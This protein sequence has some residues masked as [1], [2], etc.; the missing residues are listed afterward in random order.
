MK[1]AIIDEVHAHREKS[2]IGKYTFE[3]YKHIRKN[4]DADLLALT[5]DKKENIYEQDIEVIPPGIRLP[6]FQRTVNWQWYYP[7][8]MPEGY[9]IYHATNPFLIRTVALKPNSI[10]TIH[11]MGL[12]ELPGSSL[13]DSLSLLFG[14]SCVH[15]KV[16]KDNIR[17]IKKIIAVSNYTKDKIKDILGV[18]E[19]KIA[20]I[21]HGVNPV[22]KPM[23]GSDCRKELG[24]SPDKKIILY[25][26]TELPKKNVEILIK[27]LIEVKKE[28][29]KILLVRV[30]SSSPKIISLIKSLGLGEHV[31]YFENVNEAEL[32]LYYNAA[33]VFVF[34]S[35]YEGFGMPLLEA[36]ACGTPVIA[37]DATCFP[38]ILGDGGMLFDPA[39]AG[40][41]AKKIIRVIKDREI[42]EKMIR[43]GKEH[44]KSF[45]WENTAART[46]DAYRELYEH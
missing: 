22:F 35:L 41:L 5:G 33:D 1:I 12:F 2:G 37:A 43:A 15:K 20:V 45:T 6:V 17:Q 8:V 26:G 19:E 4:N 27:S 38:E 25:T 39:D 14:F 29:G 32:P 42:A 40:D 7:R 24:L 10:V 36:M 34:P 28:I 18:E 9:D 30:G 23:S 13:R 44:V 21:Y 31:K 3:L 16:L 11:D 46:L